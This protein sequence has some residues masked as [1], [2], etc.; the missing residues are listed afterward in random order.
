ML[1]GRHE[2]RALEP[3]IELLNYKEFG[4]RYSGSHKPNIKQSRF[5]TQ[6]VVYLLSSTT[7][8]KLVREHRCDV[9]L[10]MNG[11]K[12]EGF[13]RRIDKEIQVQ[14][15][16]ILPSSSEPN[17]RNEAASRTPLVAFIQWNNNFS[18][19]WKT[20]NKCFSPAKLCYH[21]EVI[22]NQRLTTVY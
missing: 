6:H 3:D 20:A 17:S 7:L 2:H 21:S 5:G 4:Y 18:T 19:N 12:Y 1:A 22:I 16:S 9:I 14:D 10:L 13:D 11:E 8:K 15:L